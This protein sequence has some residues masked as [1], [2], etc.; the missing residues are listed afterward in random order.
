MKRKLFTALLLLLIPQSGFATKHWAVKTGKT[1]THCHI[2]VTSDAPLNSKGRFFRQNGHSLSAPESAL[3]NKPMAGTLTE[4]GR[5]LLERK[6]WL[7][8][9]RLFNLNKIGS[10]RID[11]ASCHKDTPNGNSLSGVFKQ[12]PKYHSGLNRMADIEDAFNYCIQE[13]MEGSPLRPGTRSSLAMQ[14]YLK[15]L[16]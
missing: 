10:K 8:G 15:S 6:Y 1:C 12:Y 16:Q 13:R 3:E 11:C 14:L 7:K 5:K 2:T 9:Q 4:S